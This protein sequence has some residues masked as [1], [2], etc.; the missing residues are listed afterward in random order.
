MASPGSS[1]PLKSSRQ[2]IADAA[3]FGWDLP[4]LEKEK[5]FFLDARMSSDTVM[6]GRFDLNGML[7]TIAS[8][9]Q[10]IGATRVVSKLNSS[11]SLDW[12]LSLFIPIGSFFY[13]QTSLRERDIKNII[14]I[15][16]GNGN[17]VASK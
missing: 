7:A 17:E 11:S 5:L 1:W 14:L 12:M 3:T 4:A 15:L 8:K 2:I 13:L 16:R 9:A 10:K 6:S